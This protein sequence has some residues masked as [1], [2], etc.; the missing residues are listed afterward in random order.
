M[1]HFKDS[2][3]PSAA[4]VQ[5]ALDVFGFGHRVFEFTV[6]TRSA[7]DA[8]AAIGCDVAQ[9][10]KSLIFRGRN[11]GRPVLV[12]ANGRARVDEHKVAAACGEPIVKADAD[13]VRESTGYVIGGVCP[14]G[15][16]RRPITLID[17]G[18][19]EYEEIW[20]AAG[21]PNAV[22]KLTPEQL[23]ALTGGTLAD[24]TL[25][26]PAEMAGINIA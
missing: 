13:F 8:A 12:L 14:V 3:S 2:L 4:R 11:S 6:S 9:I 18:L 15:H 16:L 22:F 17:D 26:P 1:N 24:V 23:K 20:A 25:T 5:A 19:T 10:A 21:T 7:A